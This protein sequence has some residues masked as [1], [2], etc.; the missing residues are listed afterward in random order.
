ML[1]HDGRGGIQ[2]RPHQRRR[3]HRLDQ[4]H[5][6]G[7]RS[8]FRVGVP[9][10]ADHRFRSEVGS[11][12]PDLPVPCLG[13]SPAAVPL[14]TPN[15]RDSPPDLDSWRIPETDKVVLV[16]IGV[17]RTE[18]TPLTSVCFQEATGPS[19]STADG[20]LLY[21]VAVNQLWDHP[22]HALTASWAVEP[23]TGA[24]YYV[25]P[26]GE[27]WFANSSVALWVECLHHYGLRVD[28]CDLLLNADHHDEGAVLAELDELAAELKE[29]DPP[30]F[31][32]YQGYIWPEFLACWFW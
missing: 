13:R 24:V 21:L 3:R 1:G 10:A 11:H 28:T 23:E 7:S 14:R 4:Q 30:A 17:P 16:G 20:R 25:Q 27:T 29:C 32:G 12:A 19:L 2:H 5:V 9:P 22:S 8:D 31:E 6:G 26:G 18:D 15:P